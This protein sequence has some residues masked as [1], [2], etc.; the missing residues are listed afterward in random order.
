M[1]KT[2][3]KLSIVDASTIS[4]PLALGNWAQ[5]SRKASSVKMHL[6]LVAASP[7]VIFPDAMVPTTANVGD[8]ACAVELVIPSDTTYV[9]DRGYDDY[10]KMEGWSKEDIRFVMRLRE[11][12]FTTILEESTFEPEG[13]ILRNPKVHMSS[14]PRADKE[15]LRLIKFMNEKDRR[16][17]LVTSIWNLSAEDSLKYTNAAGS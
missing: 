4:L 17:R 7:E 12:A 16:Y 3:G 13:R 14:A 1:S 11:R 6:R 10:K 2:I 8:R 5:V 15:E 9:M